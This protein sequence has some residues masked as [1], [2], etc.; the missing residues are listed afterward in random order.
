M[1]TILVT[2]LTYACI[3]VSSCL[4]VSCYC[5]ILK[6]KFSLF[7]C[8]LVCDLG[9]NYCTV[10]HQTLRDY[11][12]G[13]QRCPPWV[14][15][16]RLAVLEEIYFNFYFL[17]MADGHFIN[18]RSLDF[19]LSGSMICCYPTISYILG[20]HYSSNPLLLTAQIL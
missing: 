5:V 13:L 17:F 11:K 3:N 19:W 15:I 20:R 6:I 4:C 8:L 14:E 12:V 9:K 2:A 1:S 7:V 18:Y 10:H 16:T